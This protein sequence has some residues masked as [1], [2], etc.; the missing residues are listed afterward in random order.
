MSSMVI[1]IVLPAIQALPPGYAPKAVVLCRAELVYKHGTL[2]FCGLG[3]LH[4]CIF[5]G[6]SQEF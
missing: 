4:S 6:E 2:C 1:I 3:V 5:M